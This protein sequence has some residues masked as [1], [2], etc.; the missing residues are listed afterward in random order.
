MK[1]LFF[2]LTG[3]FLTFQL[4]GQPDHNI[5]IFAKGEANYVLYDR[6]MGHDMG[7]GTGIEMDVNLKSGF[8]LL[9]DFNC[10]IFPTNALLTTI[11]GVEME[12]KK[13]IPVI[14]AGAA[15][16]VFRNFYI[17]IEAGPAFINSFVYPGIKPGIKYYLERKQRIGVVLSLTHVF[18]ADHSDDGAFGYADLGLVF[19]VF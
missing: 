12:K 6:A 9:L 10:D 4:A 13:T 3:L 19:R 15:C 18:R 11:D 8:R 7:F 16:P 2:F 17:S 1:T 5:S 14:F